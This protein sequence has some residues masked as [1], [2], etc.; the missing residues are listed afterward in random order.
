MC[1]DSA[2]RAEQGDY[3][4]KPR[5]GDLIR[6]SDHGPIYA[7][8]RPSGAP[9]QLWQVNPDHVTSPDQIL[10]DVASLH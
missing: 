9:V 1:G 6:L 2:Y 7:P 3:V 4:Y 8:F 10:Y 5:S